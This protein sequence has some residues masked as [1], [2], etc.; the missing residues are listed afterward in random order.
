MQGMRDK[1]EHR[2]TN[3]TRRQ[4]KGA[5][6]A[7]VISLIATLVLLIGLKLDIGFVIYFVFAGYAVSLATMGKR[8]LRI[9]FTS[10]AG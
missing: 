2:Q 6:M 10:E 5:I 4:I 8:L 3:G 1:C 7:C 9:L